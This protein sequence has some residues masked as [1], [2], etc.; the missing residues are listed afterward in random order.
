MTLATASRSS[1]TLAKM[2]SLVHGDGGLANSYVL[3]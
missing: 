2:T 1:S 3:I